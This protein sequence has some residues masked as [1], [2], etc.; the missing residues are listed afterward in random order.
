MSILPITPTRGVIF[1]RNGIILADNI[2]VYLLEITPEHVKDIRKTLVELRALLPSITDDDIEHFKRARQQNSSFVPIPLKLKLSQEEVAIF[3]SQQYRFNGVNVTAHLMRYYPFK[4]ITAH[5][6][7]Y[8]GRIN[9]Q[10]LNKIDNINYRGT[11]FIGK[12]G[13]EKYYEQL[14]HGRVGNQ[15]V[16]TDVSGRQIRI[17]HKQAPLPGKKLTLTL[18]IHLQKIAAEALKDK[19]GAVVVIDPNN[20]EILAMVSSPSYDPNK[21]VNGISIPDYNELSAAKNRPLY[22]R[23]LRGMYPPA[24]TIKPYVALS[25]LEN[26]VIDAKYKIFDPG[27]YGL[28]GI[29]YIYRDWKKSGHGIIQIERA[30]TVSCDT[31]F[32][33]LGHRLGIKAL[34]ATLSKFGFG[35]LTNIDLTEELPGILPDATW[36][37]AIKGTP[38]YSG[39]TLITSIGQGFFLASPLQM[40][41]AVATLSQRGIHHTPHLLQSRYSHQKNDQIVLENASNWEIVINGMRAV[42]TSNEGTG[43]KFGRDAKYSVAGKTGTAQVISGRKYEKTRYTDIPEFLRDHSLFIAFA[44]ATKPLIAI[45]VMVEN[46]AAASIIARTVLDAYFMNHAYT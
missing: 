32:Y 28:P 27:W 36:K 37:Q 3:A 23:A 11:N 30:I 45:A 4:E 43:Y 16:E 25:G 19:R 39:D 35:R 29:N 1:D 41:V 14:L 46:D 24:S 44:P 9:A 31:Y 38:W 34:A 5:I 7:G 22:N 42:I 13:L 17:L 2:P 15:Q 26:G 40:A 10:E 18:D 21:F 20:G 33:H 8:V 6:L 12:T